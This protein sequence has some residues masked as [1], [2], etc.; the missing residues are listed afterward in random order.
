[1]ADKKQQKNKKEQKHK[2][3]EGEKGGRAQHQKQQDENMNVDQETYE[4]TD[5]DEI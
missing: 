2:R 3:E 4:Y 1:M 5:I